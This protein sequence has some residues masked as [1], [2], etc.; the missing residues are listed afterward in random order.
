MTMQIR[1]NNVPRFTIDG[2][3]LTPKER[4]QFDYLTDA[5]GGLFFRYKGNVYD[6]ADFMRCESD[7]LKAW[8]G[9]ASGSYFH[10]VLIK[11]VD[12]GER[13]IVGQYFS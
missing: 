4:E 5:Q 13:V 7:E 9:Y 11:L 3:Y 6:I 2:F 10:G 12:D 8:D 1:T